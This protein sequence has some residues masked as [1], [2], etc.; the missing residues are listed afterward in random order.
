MI[1]DDLSRRCW[2]IS[3]VVAKDFPNV[4]PEDLYVDL[5]TLFWSYTSKELSTTVLYDS[6]TILAESRRATHLQQSAQYDYRPSEV[7]KILEHVWDEHREF[8]VEEA[9]VAF[10][11]RRLEWNDYILLESIYRDGGPPAPEYRVRH[12]E[13]LERLTDRLNSYSGRTG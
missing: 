5:G 4:T 3:E 7:E 13:A 6:V 9:D 11:L 10:E 2:Q 1:D 8:S 12:R